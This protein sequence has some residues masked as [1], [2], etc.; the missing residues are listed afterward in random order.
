MR[1]FVAVWPDESTVECL[2]ALPLGPADRISLVRPG[3]WHV[4]LRFFGDVDPD[5]VPTLVAAL[6]AAARKLPDS[7][8][9]EV[10]P[11]TSWF[12]GHRV[13]QIPVS[14]LDQAAAAVRDATAS[15]VP[16]RDPGN[17]RFVGHLTVARSPRR[18]LN[19]SERSA[20]AGVPFASSFEAESLDL[21]A[22]ETG[23]GGP[24]YTTLARVSL[25]G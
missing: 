23:R 22:S 24:R 15:V 16:D 6:E 1:M 19:G 3:R 12:S 8:R 5:L 25:R 9:C 14:G 13:L 11:R 17:V 7:I 4:T 2:S 20:L 10:G 21:V 18:G